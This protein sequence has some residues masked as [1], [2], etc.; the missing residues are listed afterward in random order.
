MTQ[1]DCP[2]PG[3]LDIAVRAVKRLPHIWAIPIATVA[4]AVFVASMAEAKGKPQK[5][6]AGAAATPAATSRPAARPKSTTPAAQHAAP[7]GPGH[8][9]SRK[10]QSAGHGHGGTWS[11]DDLF[12]HRDRWGPQ[13]SNV[14]EGSLPAVVP[15][16]VCPADMAI[17]DSRYC[18]DR[19]EASLVEVSASGSEQP[20]SPFGALPDGVK[21]KARSA[22]G[23]YPQGYISAAQAQSACANAGKRL[24]NPTEWRQACGGPQKNLWSYGA[25][26]V[27]GRCNDHGRS[28]MLHYF[29]QVAESWTLV[30]M[31]EMND[32]RLNQWEGTL[33]RTG[34]S[35]DC[36]NE[37]GV[38]DM[39]GNL[40]EWTSDPNGTFQGGWYLDTHIN[41][42]GCGYRTTAHEFTYH[43]YSTGFRCCADALPP[44]AAP[45]V[46]TPAAV[47]SPAATTAAPPAATHPVD[48]TL[49]PQAAPT[50]TQHAPNPRHPEDDDPYAL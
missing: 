28:P 34:E 1:N 7:H 33:M 6:H 11:A 5:K 16:G 49:A 3:K 17:I 43:D 9:T 4:F 44:G 35:A 36:T 29:P 39:V 24:C 26:H 20:W 45:T 50:A 15:G 22:P 27:A 38:Y 8:A 18:V 42:D 46:A 2:R 40:H 30:G 19:Y 12:W 13:G 31:P 21:F 48:D 37:Y 23:V 32:D 41:G 25:T 47:A 10:R 14:V